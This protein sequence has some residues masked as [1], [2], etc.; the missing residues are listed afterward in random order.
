MKKA[1]GIAQERRL[2]DRSRVVRLPLLPLVKKEGM[3]PDNALLL[4]LNVLSIN[5]CATS[6]SILP[7]KLLYA[8]V[9]V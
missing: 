1:S 7:E 9:T 8:R 6:V 5:S 4:T 3:A 2:F